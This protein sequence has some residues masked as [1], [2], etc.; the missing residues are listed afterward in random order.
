MKG[1]VCLCSSRSAPKVVL[2][3]S[4]LLSLAAQ[5]QMMS[6]AAPNMDP[7]APASGLITLLPSQDL[8]SHRKD[9]FKSG[10]HSRGGG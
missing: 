1:C 10:S 6:L 7:K 8:S 9:S 4:L 5:Y 2:T 3:H